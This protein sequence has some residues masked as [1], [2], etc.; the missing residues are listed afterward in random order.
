M[1]TEASLQSITQRVCALLECSNVLLSL[2]PSST[3]CYPLS[4]R[5]TSSQESDLACLLV[6]EEVQA[7]IS[8][9]IQER[10]IQFCNDCTLQFHNMLIRSVAIVPLE[11]PVGSSGF[12]MCIDTQVDKFLH[13][14]YA[15]LEQVIPGIAQE[16][17]QAYA[18]TS[19]SL[20][21]QADLIPELQQYYL[22]IIMEQAAHMEV[23]VNDLI[24][25]S[26]VMGKNISTELLYHCEKMSS[27]L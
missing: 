11:G 13:G 1:I 6:H 22:G 26:R 12:L 21:T 15:L 16:L 25:M 27:L 14:E 3:D 18:S 5:V 24:A 8:C 10:S 7:L 20:S 4:N 19:S 17:E 2:T 9:A 23:L